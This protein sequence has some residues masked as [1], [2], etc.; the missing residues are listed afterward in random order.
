MADWIWALVG[1]AVTLSVTVAVILWYA[2]K[3]LD[4]KIERLGDRL[5]DKMDRKFDQV[6]AGIAETKQLVAGHAERIKA[7][8][9]QTDRLSSAVFAPQ[10]FDAPSPR[11]DVEHAPEMAAP[12]E[13]AAPGEG[14]AASAG[15][16]EPTPPTAAVAP[17]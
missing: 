6:M 4:D 3:H 2:F 1:V 10:R 13:A 9:N 17:A 11:H 12:A 16:P 7:L 8:E 15:G 14:I 5:D